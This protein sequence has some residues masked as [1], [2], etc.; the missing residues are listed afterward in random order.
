[1][2]SFS[3]AHELDRPSKRMATRSGVAW[4]WRATWWT[5]WA[6]LHGR[7]FSVIERVVRPEA[8]LVEVGEQSLA[9]VEHMRANCITRGVRVVGAGRSEQP[10]VVAPHCAA[11]LSVAAVEVS[12]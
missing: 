1:M 10:C 12:R 7:R 6:P 2:R 3:C 8:D 9:T 5:Q 4:A 11:P